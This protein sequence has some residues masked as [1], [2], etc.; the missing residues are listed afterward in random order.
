M[1]MTL[2]IFSA[3]EIALCSPAF[4]A[5]AVKLPRQRAIQNVIHQRRFA[6]TRNARH[7][8]H[9]AERKRHIQILEII[10][11]R[12]QNRQRRAV[13]LR[14][15]PAAS[16][17]CVRPEMYA[18]VSES[19]SRMISSG[20]PCATRLAAMSSRARPEIHDIIRAADRLFIVL[21]HQHRVAQVAQILPA[22]SAAGRYPDDAARSTARPAHTSTPRSF[23]PICV[24]SRIRCP[25][26]PDKVAAERSSEMY[27]KPTA[28]KNCSR[29][30][31]SCM[32][33]PAIVRLAAGQLD[34]C[35]TSS[36]RATGIA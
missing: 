14:A 6:G 31:I 4:F 17:S 28:F 5:R 16:Q 13:R 8:R 34:A 19:G 1:R 7:H 29:S 9:H 20:V 2:S 35:A 23:D 25:S 18:P 15:A 21:H 24:A 10:F 32:T 3:P 27:P 11:F 26:P 22:Q 12:A 30:T 36:D 33:R